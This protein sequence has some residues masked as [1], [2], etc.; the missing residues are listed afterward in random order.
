MAGDE[1]YYSGSKWMK[2]RLSVW[3]VLFVLAVLVL[4]G[5]DLS[6]YRNQGNAVPAGS[7]SPV[8]ASQVPLSTPAAQAKSTNPAIVPAQATQSLDPS[9]Q[10]DV[11]STDVSRTA[12]DL[13]QSLDGV[14]KDLDSS[15]TLNDVR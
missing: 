9:A 7:T 10:Q 11:L 15:D 13:S 6:G 1:P 12:D 4:T 3:I 8:V 5:C 14:V 2:T